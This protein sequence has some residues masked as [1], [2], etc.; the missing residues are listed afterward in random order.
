MDENGAEESKALLTRMST[1]PKVVAT[2][3]TATLI[4]SA[5]PMS[6]TTCDDGYSSIKSSH[7]SFLS[8]ESYMLGRY[9]QAIGRRNFASGV[10]RGE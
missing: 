9:D 8:V 7:D 4:W 6:Q 3:S 10:L 2:F 5:L 1:P